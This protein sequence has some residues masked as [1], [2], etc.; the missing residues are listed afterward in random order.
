MNSSAEKIKLNEILLSTDR[1]LC[2]LQIIELFA[3]PLN[4]F[5]PRSSIGG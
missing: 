2:G 4:T 5:V 3:L 1:S